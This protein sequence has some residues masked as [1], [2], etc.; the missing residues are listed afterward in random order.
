MQKKKLGFTFLIIAL[1]CLTGCTKQLKGPDGKVVMNEE[2]G[3]VLPSN[4]LCAPTDEDIL[5]LY[6]ENKV[7]LEKKYAEQ[8]EAGDIGQK[9][10]DKKINSIMNVD[11][12]DSCE[13]F[14]V[15]GMDDGIWTGIFVTPLSWVLIKV[16]KFLGNYGLAIIFVTLLIRLIMYPVTLKTA[17]QSENLKLAKPEIDKIEKKYKNKNDQ[18][19]MT[20]KAQEQMLLYKR[21]HI[22][23]FS[24]CL[25]SLIQIPLFFAFYEAL[26]RLP[27]L[28][29]DKLLGFQMSVSPAKGIGSGNWLYLILPVLVFFATYFS[30]KLNSG[31]GMTGDQAK[32][33][34]T[35]MNIMNI[36]ITFMSFTMSSAII[37]YWITNNTFTIIQNL[38][39]KRSTKNDKVV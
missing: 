37:F 7:A 6:R 39:V 1:L 29:E 20:R 15:I 35:T 21:Y 13:N 9:E 4:I 38:I 31:A 30:F 2:T 26:Y 5:N 3:Q 14:P 18:E 8:L 27:V 22:N 19:S 23:P 12:Y 34:K 16:G 17:K 32:Q 36:V 33:M 28:F 24:G 10:Y 11:D 25:Y